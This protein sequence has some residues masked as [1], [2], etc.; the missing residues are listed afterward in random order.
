MRRLVRRWRALSPRD[1]AITALAGMGIWIM[2]LPDYASWGWRA[3]LGLLAIMLER[4]FAIRLAIA[5]VEEP[6]ADPPPLPSYALACL[7][8]ALAV[9]A[10]NLVLPP[11]RIPLTPEV[12]AALDFYRGFA[13]TLLVG[14][15][16]TLI[17]VSLRRSV[18]AGLALAAAERARAEEA[19]RLARLRVEGFTLRLDPAAAVERLRALAATYRDDP[20]RADM[21]VDA[22]I[23]QLR[24]GLAATRAGP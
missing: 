24:A 11:S 13:P 15:P 21:E 14:L 20:G 22:L 23:A 17:H 10:G 3:N 8:A 2:F 6:G 16:L 19:L 4:V 5:A 1:L 9:G 18:A 7:A 12:P